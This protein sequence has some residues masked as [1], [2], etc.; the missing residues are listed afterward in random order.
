MA[1][2]AQR[3]VAMKAPANAT[4]GESSTE[5]LTQSEQR[6]EFLSLVNTDLTNGVYIAFGADA[7]YQKGIYL[8]PNGGALLLDMECTSQ[9]VNGIVGPGSST[10]PVVAVQEG[11]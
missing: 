2:E 8:A 7:E 4:I 6:R 9:A 3:Q 5:I 10:S 1:P 11:N